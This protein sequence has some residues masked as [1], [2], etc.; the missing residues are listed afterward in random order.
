[1]QRVS[2]LD[3]RFN[4]EGREYALIERLREDGSVIEYVV[5]AGIKY[6]NFIHIEDKI[7]CNAEWEQGYYCGKNHI[8]AENFFNDLT[9]ERGYI[10]D[11]LSLT[12]KGYVLSEFEYKIIDRICSYDNLPISLYQKNE[13][14]YFFDLED[15]KII[16]LKKG[17]GDVEDS[18]SAMG[19][20]YYLMN[21]DDIQV[22]CDLMGRFGVKVDMPPVPTKKATKYKEEPKPYSIT[23]TKIYEIKGYF[24]N[25]NIWYE[26]FKN[27]KEFNYVKEKIFNNECCTEWE[28]IYLED[29]KLTSD[30]APKYIAEFLENH[31]EIFANET[32]YI[33]KS[34]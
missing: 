31:K 32:S 25:G 29:T 23:K 11:D 22:Y 1:M 4:N 9:K 27:E 14:D 18:R 15:E 26:H 19:F 12:D 6:E 7:I 24:N 5:A 17:F 13:K 16:G 30:N 34:R 21:N 8:K 20:E 28:G 10:Y 2:I 3:Q 33:K